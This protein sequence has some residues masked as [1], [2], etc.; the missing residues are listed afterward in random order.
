MFILPAI[1][2]IEVEVKKEQGLLSGAM[3]LNSSGELSSTGHNEVQEEISFA[4]KRILLFNT[5]KAAVKALEDD[6]Y[7]ARPPQ[8]ASQEV[9]DE[10]RRLIGN[11]TLVLEDFKSPVEVPIIS[12]PV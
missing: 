9:I 3:F 8:F 11:A 10:F 5:L 4:Q 12:T 6:G 7:P 1:S 2:E